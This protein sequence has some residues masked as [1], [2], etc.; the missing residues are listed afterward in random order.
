MD[1]YQLTRVHFD[2]IGLDYE[3]FE[4]ENAEYL[5]G[6]QNIGSTGILS[7]VT[8]FFYKNQYSYEIVIDDFI[9]VESDTNQF[10]DMMKLCNEFNCETSYFKMFITESGEVRV[11]MIKDYNEFHPVELVS[12][13]FSI[14]NILEDNYI[15]RFM[16]IKWVN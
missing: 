6:Y 2:K 7:T 3:T 5:I 14:F 12:T 10:I 15:A 1:A 4:N 16:R 11:K 8:I 9:N 13:L